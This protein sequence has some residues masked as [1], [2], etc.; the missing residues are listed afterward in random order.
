MFEGGL[1]LGALVEFFASFFGE[2][3]EDVF[4][5][6]ESIA[7]DFP[8]V[9]EGFEAGDDAGPLHEVGGGIVLVEFAPE[10][11]GG[12]LE[13]VCGIGVGRDEGADEAMDVCFMTSE[14]ADEIL[15]AVFRLLV[16]LFTIIRLP[17]KCYP[18][19]FFQNMNEK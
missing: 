2:E 4:A 11:E 15:V 6:D 19:G 1:F 12:L 5:E 3:V 16:C 8:P 7:G 13:D 9:G 14:G 18:H 17:W 10:D